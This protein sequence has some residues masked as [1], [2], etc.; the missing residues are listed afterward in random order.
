MALRAPV[1]LGMQ[2]PE[3]AAPAQAG[4]GAAHGGANAAS[5]ILK[6]VTLVIRVAGAA[7]GQVRMRARARSQPGPKITAGTSS[8]SVSIMHS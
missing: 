7:P 5:P 4:G 8:S 2:A 3:E 1:Q 6:P